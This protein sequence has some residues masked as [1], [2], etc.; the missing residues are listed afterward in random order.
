V[1]KFRHIELL[2]ETLYLFGFMLM[3]PVEKAVGYA[4]VDHPGLVCHQI[5]EISFLVHGFRDTFGQAG[6]TYP[7]AFAFRMT[8]G[9]GPE[10]TTGSMSVRST[11]KAGRLASATLPGLQPVPP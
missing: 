5:N 9:E 4:C 7:S 11:Q 8:R 6:G 1:D 3:D 10:I 2:G